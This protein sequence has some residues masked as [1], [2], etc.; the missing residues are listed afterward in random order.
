M[1]DSDVLPRNKEIRMAEPKWKKHRK[2]K[3]IS[4]C[5]DRQTA[6]ISHC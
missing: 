3:P 4:I 6:V 1:I 2:I 5:A